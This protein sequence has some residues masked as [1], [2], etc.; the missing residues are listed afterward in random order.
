MGCGFGLGRSA[1]L[2]CGPVFP[3]GPLDA[4]WLDRLELA[5]ARLGPPNEG[6]P[7]IRVA[8]RVGAHA[9][10]LDFDREGCR[11][12]RDA[13]GAA[14]VTFSATE[15]VAAALARGE[16]T[17]AEAILAGDLSVGGDGAA[18]LPWR[19]VLDD[20]ARELQRSDGA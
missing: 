20:L 14:T 7:P 13:T 6:A 18:L 4:A 15:A 9:F 17:T 10:A 5:A 2:P 19:A 12:T 16:R 11:L 3:P 8:Y 1:P